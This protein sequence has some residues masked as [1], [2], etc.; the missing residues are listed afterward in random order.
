MNDNFYFEIFANEVTVAKAKS[1]KTIDLFNVLNFKQLTSLETTFESGG[2]R[3]AVSIDSTIVFTCNFFEGITAFKIENGQIL[4]KNTKIKSIQKIDVSDDGL[5]LFIVTERKKFYVVDVKT[6]ELIK[7]EKGISSFFKL[8]ENK[9]LFINSDN[10]ISLKSQVNTKLFYKFESY[11]LD[12]C[13]TEGNIIFS[14][15]YKPLTMIEVKTGNKIWQSDLLPGYRI[16]YLKQV[17]EDI[18]SMVGFFNNGKIDEKYL[19]NL[20]T[21][22]GM[23]TKKTQLDSLYHS[24]CFSPDGLKLYCSNL[25]VYDTLNHLKIYPRSP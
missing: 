11:I 5:H 2:T 6:G 25:D 17:S 20:E 13:S 18:I 16:N 21:K 19:F 12:V 7:Q 24:F 15:M 1:E 23:I 14:E 10:S 22:S 3:L 8:P 9:V 4:W